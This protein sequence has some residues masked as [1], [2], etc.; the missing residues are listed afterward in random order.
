MLLPLLY[1][2]LRPDGAEVPGR[3]SGGWWLRALKFFPVQHLPTFLCG[4]LLARL[5]TRVTVSNAMRCLLT[6]GGVAGVV[7]FQVLAFHT[8]DRVWLYPLLHDPLLVPFYA[9]IIFG[10]SADHWLAWLIGHPWLVAVGEASYCLYILHFGIWQI[11]HE[12]GLLHWM[13]LTRWDPW[14]SY[15]MILAVSMLAYHWFELPARTLVR[16]WTQ[17]RNQPRF[18]TAAD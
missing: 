6:F 4:I 5:Q 9:C 17:R 12:H 15:A 16:R 10:L 13:R 14:I 7:G 2:V 3:F 18:A 8:G 1:I 11:L